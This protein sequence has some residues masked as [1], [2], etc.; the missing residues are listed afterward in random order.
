[1]ILLKNA[2]I[3]TITNGDLEKASLLIENGKIKEINEYIDVSDYNNLKT[4]DC[5]KYIVTPGLIDEHSHIGSWEDGLGWEGNDINEMTDPINPGLH[6]IDAVNP[7]DVA[8][9]DALS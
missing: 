6:I 2:Y 8:F 3:K 4:I 1:M 5:S 7:G 9:S